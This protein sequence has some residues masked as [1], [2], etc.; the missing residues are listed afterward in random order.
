MKKRMKRIKNKAQWSL[1]LKPMTVKIQGL[2]S[3][4]VLQPVP[5]FEN[6]RPWKIKQKS[7]A[8][9]FYWRFDCNMHWRRKR[10]SRADFGSPKICQKICRGRLIEVA[11]NRKSGALKWPTKWGLL[12]RISSSWSTSIVSL[13]LSTTGQGAF[14]FLEQIIVCRPFSRPYLCLYSFFQ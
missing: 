2:P 6:I 9:C 8:E 4:A 11:I 13:M 3:S 5:V 7:I 12:W 1:E 14:E 10:K